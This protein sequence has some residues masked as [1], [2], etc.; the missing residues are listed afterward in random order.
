VSWHKAK[1]DGAD[2]AFSLYIRTRDNWTCQKCLKI[3]TPPTNALHCSHFVGRGKEN[4]RFSEANACALCFHCHQY[5]TSHP[6]EHYDWQVKR[7]GQEV[8]DDLKFESTLYMKKDRR[9]QQMYWES[10]LAKLTQSKLTPKQAKDMTQSH[11][12]KNLG[13]EPSK[14]DGIYEDYKRNKLAYST[15]SPSYYAGKVP[16]KTLCNPMQKG[17]FVTYRKNKNYGKKILHRTHTKLKSPPK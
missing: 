5:F 6:A 15:Y 13:G 3:Y 2:K 4:T 17:G 1:I 7:L 14:L 9:L 8:V 12:K 16:R 10:E 11:I